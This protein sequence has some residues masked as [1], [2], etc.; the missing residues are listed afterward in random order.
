MDKKI[1]IIRFSSFG[2]IV[3]CMGILSTLKLSYPELKVDWV[4]KDEFTTLVSSNRHV[5]K[6]WGLGPRK[7]FVDLIKLAFKLKSEGYTYIYDAHSNLRSFFLSLIVCPPWQRIFKTKWFHRPK[8]RLKRFFLFKLGMNFF[9]RPYKGMESYLRPLKILDVGKLSF[10]NPMNFSPDDFKKSEK[11]IGES[12][13]DYISLA[14]SAAW[15]MKRWPLEN[16]KKLILLEKKRKF[17]ILGGP[18]DQFCQ[19]LE[20][21]DPNRVINLAGK[22]NLI[23]SCAI[24]SA[25]K[26]LISG[27]TGLLHVADLIGKKA[28]SLIGPTAFGF[29]SSPAVLTLEKEMSCRPCSK[30]GR[31]NCKDSVYQKCMVDILPEEVCEKLLNHF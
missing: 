5:D 4:T 22:L 2:D 8:E 29:T 23:E 24:I 11:I 20:D 12:V 6:V 18:K 15:E 19:E 16:F 14:P 13:S 21:I 17:L 3:Q 31:G 9:P 7:S 26:G 1:L 30:D 10:D 28:I 25:S 27:D